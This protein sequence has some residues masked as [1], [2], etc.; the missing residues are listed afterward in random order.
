MRDPIHTTAAT[1]KT[2]AMTRL[3]LR[4]LDAMAGDLAAIY[5]NAGPQAT[6]RPAD[7]GI[8]LRVSSTRVV[9]ISVS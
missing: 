9:N 1:A 2:T 3:G 8:W 7:V 6:V 4:N 5:K